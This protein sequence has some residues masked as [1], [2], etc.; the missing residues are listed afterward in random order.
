MAEVR[1]G[2]MIVQTAEVP[3]NS[4]R[5]PFKGAI[6]VSSSPAQLQRWDSI[7]QGASAGDALPPITVQ[8]G[9]R[10]PSIFDIF[11]E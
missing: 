6:D 5:S 11:F 10:G 4:L 8:P 7:M 1:V 3:L 2:E 9:S